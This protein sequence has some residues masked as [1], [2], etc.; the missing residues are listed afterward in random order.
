MNKKIIALVLVFA[1]ALC[2]V[3]AASTSGTA[4]KDA[5]SVG[6]G[7]GTNSGVAVKYGMGK[8]DVQGNVGIAIKNSKVAFSGDVGAF[9]DFYDINFNTGALTKTQTISLTT[10]PVVGLNVQDGSLGLDIVW[11]VGAEYTF[12]KVPVTMFLKLGGG[13]GMLFADSVNGGFTFYGVLGAVYTF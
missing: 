7:L 3:S 2:A 10:G 6:I 4:K 8:F 12:G 9:Y 13:Y 1:L 11:T 5:F